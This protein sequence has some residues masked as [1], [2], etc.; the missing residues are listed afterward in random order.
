[1]LINNQENN[2]IEKKLKDINTN[3]N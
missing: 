2:F 3:Q 1:M